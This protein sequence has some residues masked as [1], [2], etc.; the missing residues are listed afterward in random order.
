LGGGASALPPGEL[1]PARKALEDGVAGV[2]R[3]LERTFLPEI[4]KSRNVVTQFEIHEMSDKDSFFVVIE[5]G[6][7]VIRSGVHDAPTFTVSASEADFADFIE[8]PGSGPELLREG[9]LQIRPF[10]LKR[11]NDFLTSFGMFGAV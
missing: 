6:S 9:R 10:D 3:E 2:R 8:K 5:N 7:L 1:L 11:L 4:A